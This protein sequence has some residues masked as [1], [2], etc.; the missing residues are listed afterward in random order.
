MKQYLLSVYHPETEA[1]DNVDQIMRDAID[2][3][4]MSAPLS[5]EQLAEAIQIPPRN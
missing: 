1:P 3:K 5:N 4:F 2:F